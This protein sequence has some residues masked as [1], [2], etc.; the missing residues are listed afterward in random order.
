MS[1]PAERF[2][3]YIESLCLKLLVQSSNDPYDV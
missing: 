1:G 3:I 2:E